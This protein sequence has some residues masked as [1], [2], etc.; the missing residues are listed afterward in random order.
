MVEKVINTIYLTG[1]IILLLV[2]A[3]AMNSCGTS[4]QCNNKMINKYRNW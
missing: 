1:G 2:V 4:K 3:M